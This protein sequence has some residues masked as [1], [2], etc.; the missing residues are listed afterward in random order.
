MEEM[1]VDKQALIT[2]IKRVFKKLP[3]ITTDTNAM[4]FIGQAMLD[5]YKK[6]TGEELSL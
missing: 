6:L 3:S 1:S 4:F 2:D 5:A